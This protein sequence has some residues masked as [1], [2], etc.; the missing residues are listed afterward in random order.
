MELADIADAT[1]CALAL[2]APTSFKPVVPSWSCRWFFLP[3]LGEARF[4]SSMGGAPIQP[5]LKSNSPETLDL[6]LDE[7]IVFHVGCDGF[8]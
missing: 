5:I 7:A 6:P 1:C 4:E 2:A 8:Y 3:L